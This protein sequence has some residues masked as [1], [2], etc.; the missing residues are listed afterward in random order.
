VLRQ[1]T[2]KFLHRV[3]IH[4]GEFD[5]SARA[6]NRAEESNLLQAELRKFRGS[7]FERKQMSTTIKRIALVAVAA[8]GLGVVSSAPSNAAPVFAFTTIGDATAGQAL[9]GGQAVVSLTPDTNTSTI[10]TVSG[11]GSVVSTSEAATVVKVGTSLV[12]WTDSSTVNSA[13]TGG[14]QSITVYS[15]VEG[16]TTI[17][18]RPLGADGSPGTAV[19]RTITWVTALAKNSATSS[20]EYIKKYDA[21]GV[22]ASTIETADSTT[23]QLSFD[24][25][26]A[27]TAPKAMIWVKQF[28]ASD[29]TTVSTVAAGKGNAIKVEIS[30]AGSLGIAN[31][32][33]TGSTVSILGSATTLDAA[34]LFHVYSDGRSGP[35]TITITVGT[36]VTTK[37]VTFVGT[38]ASYKVGTADANVLSKLQL[39]V[40]ET[41][42][43]GIDSF[44]ALNNR[45]A[46]N[47]SLTSSSDTAT[48]ATIS[49]FGANSY[50]GLYTITGVKEGVARFKF[51]DG[52]ASRDLFVGITVTKKTAKTIAVAFDKTSYAPGEKV[53]WTITAK[54]SD[55]KNIADGARAIFGSVEANLSVTNGTLFGTSPSFVDGV[56]TGSFFAPAAA[57]GRF[58]ITVSQGAADDARIAALAAASTAGLPAPTAVKTPYGFDIVNSA[59]DAALDAANEAATAAQDATDAAIQAADAAD[60]AT[61]AVAALQLEVN[62]LIAGLKKQ[63]TTLTNLVKNLAKAV[64]KK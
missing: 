53:T 48:V 57:S 52:T 35:A 8:M 26:I 63:L 10:V 44:D 15:A 42:T 51:T 61:A 4:G 9:V 1:L 27:T 49:A 41:A 54:D 55:G 43:V 22:T 6:M 37:R 19:T 59:T 7:T 20:A 39:G 40:G 14:A 56:A 29:T 21:T 60:E 46:E 31:N 23:A 38:A 33:A 64:A 25:A 13:T 12:Q 58:E 11:V 32:Q 47:V 28:S 30:G 17:T 50:T 18:A 16:V 36:K 3:R 62:T 2:N 45:V 34:N 5:S 24:A